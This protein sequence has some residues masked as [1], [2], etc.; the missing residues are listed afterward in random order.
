MS[1]LEDGDSGTLKK[2]NYFVR[3]APELVSACR[4]L[5]AGVETRPQCGETF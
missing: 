2:E 1:R 3:G 4:S 5:V